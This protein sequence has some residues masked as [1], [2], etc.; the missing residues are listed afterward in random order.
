[1]H[2]D[3][4][5]EELTTMSMKNGNLY[6]STKAYRVVCC[7]ALCIDQRILTRSEFRLQFCF[8]QPKIS[9]L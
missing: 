9:H 5:K 2:R 8:Q 3:V 6:L 7:I 1:M 4:N